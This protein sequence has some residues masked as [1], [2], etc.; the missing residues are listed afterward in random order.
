VRE[1]VRSVIVQARFVVTAILAARAAHADDTVRLK[2]C[3]LVSDSPP[4]TGC[5]RVDSVKTPWGRATLFSA[6][7]PRAPE[8]ASGWL[9]RGEY[10][11]A[12]SVVLPGLD[13]PV[14]FEE[15]GHPSNHPYEQCG[16]HSEWCAQTIRSTPQLGVD[17]RGNVSLTVTTITRVQR[18]TDD[19][20]PRSIQERRSD[21]H[22][23]QCQHDAREG[24][25]CE[26]R[27]P[28][29]AR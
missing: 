24:W 27:S 18:W 1:L 2:P 26:D 4:L 9:K 12:Y 29:T 7:D 28:S 21:V 25:R 14:T 17:K 10:L 11:V 19:K 6:N 5:H 3:Q 13:E 23:L 15:G 8:P 20:P 16:S 22:A